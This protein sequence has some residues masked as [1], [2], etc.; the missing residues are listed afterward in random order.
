MDP[1]IGRCIPWGSR[2]S[3]LLFVGFL[4]TRLLSLSVK[5]FQILASCAYAPL[6]AGGA[7]GPSRVLRRRRGVVRAV[8]PTASSGL[9]RFTRVPCWSCEPCVLLV[10]PFVQHRRMVD[11]VSRV[12]WITTARVRK[13][14]LLACVQGRLG[15][16]L[17]GSVHISNVGFGPTPHGD[18]PLTGM[19]DARR[20]LLCLR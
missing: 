15:R 2:R 12:S 9:V 16:T 13:W 4:F 17:T 7:P 6:R 8:V 14:A 20:V 18:Y 10:K 5:C 1:G 19:Y 11:P 3:V